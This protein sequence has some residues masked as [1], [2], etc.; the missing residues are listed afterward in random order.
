MR[1]RLSPALGV[2]VPRPS[3]GAVLLPLLLVTASL[4]IAIAILHQQFTPVRSSQTAQ[5]VP[6]KSGKTT[7]NSGSASPKYDCAGN[8]PHRSIE[9]EQNVERA[10]DD[11]L[12]LLET[13]E[14]CRRM[15]S[16]NPTYAINLLKRLRRD[17]VIIISDSYP[18]VSRLSP[19]GK[20][21]KV[22]ESKKLQSAAALTRGLVK[23]KSRELVRPCIYINP[24]EFIVTG[25]RAENYA[26]YLLDPP[27]QRAVAMLH[28]LAHV[29]GILPPD[30]EPD[31]PKDLK[32]RSV[33]NTDCVRS[34]CVSCVFSACPAL[35][36]RSRTRQT[37]RLKV[38]IRRTWKRY[39]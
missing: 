39:P 9:G 3:I 33:A 30:G 13:C 23:S 29:A 19:D 10:I 28:E 38:V 31:Q 17:K 18:A 27:V 35:P 6:R 1:T 7:R 21:L 14:A 32:G 24:T 26:L 15:F 4:V 12:H 2:V 36:P 25:K 11:A 5:S 16:T 20:R 8:I 37:D 22:Y 34:N